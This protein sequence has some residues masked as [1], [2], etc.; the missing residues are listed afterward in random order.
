VRQVIRSE[1]TEF[2][3]ERDE[4]LMPRLGAWLDTP[5][6]LLASN[7]A[8]PRGDAADKMGGT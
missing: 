1:A 6:A 5:D 3:Y 7:E 8:K 2:L 4:Q